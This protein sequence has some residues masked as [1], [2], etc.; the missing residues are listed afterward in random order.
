MMIGHMVNEEERRKSREQVLVD[1][2]KIKIKMEE[3]TSC[4][5]LSN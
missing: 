5:T 2:N 1:K 3:D 4:S